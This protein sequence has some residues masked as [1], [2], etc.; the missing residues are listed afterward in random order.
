MSESIDLKNITKF[1]GSNFQLWKFQ[2][3]SIL[4]AT[5]L[6]EITEGTIAKPEP[7]Q[8][9]YAA[10]C[11][12]NAKAMCIIS[13]SMEYSQ[14][15]YL[16]TC[17]TAAEM[18]SKLSTIEQKSASNKLTLM[19]KF[20]EYKMSSTDTVAQHVAKIE[21]MARQ[22]KDV[23]EELSEVMIIAKILGTLPSKFN[24]LVTAWDSVSERD[25]KKE[26]LVER[27][28]KE[29]SRLTTVDET[30]NALAAIKVQDGSTNSKD[31]PSHKSRNSDKMSEAFLVSEPNC[32]TRI[33][34][35]DVKDVWILDSGASKHM[36]FRREWFIDLD[37]S[38]RETVSLGDESICKVMGRGTILIKRFGRRIKIVRS[39]NGIEF[40]NDRMSRYMA[41]RGITLETSA[42][43]V[44]EQ[45]GRA[46]REIRTIVESARTMLTARKLPTKLWA[47]AKKPDLSHIRIFG[48]DAY[49][50]IP[51]VQRKKWDPK[52]RKLMLVGYHQ[53]STNYRLFD[54]AT[55][56]IIT[57]KDVIINENSIQDTD[58]E[59]SRFTISTDENGGV[60]PA[61]DPPRNNTNGAEGT[62]HNEER[63]DEPDDQ[64][65]DTGSILY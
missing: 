60:A 34:N 23:G 55:N 7:T 45:N 53:E 42:P 25:Q 43:Y 1:D 5:G 50:H 40:K 17:E 21:N 44:H 56:K 8:D 52:S 35:S 27:L 51:K 33:L 46:E 65:D 4:V 47:E 62:H 64:T 6:L 57:A 61:V 38:Y 15:E 11:T 16:I 14:L 18:W 22:L 63:E 2:L 54:P 26:V 30:S 39:D 59:K 32:Y 10:W 3:R 20:H 58:N 49:V 36:S 31:N 29:E 9:T 28:I 19:T 37:E 48:S 24:A 12:R 13:S 41:S